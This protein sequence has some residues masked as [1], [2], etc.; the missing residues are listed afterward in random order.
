VVT[1]HGQK[2]WWQHGLLHRDGGRPAVTHPNGLKEWWVRGTLHRYGGLLTATST[3][4]RLDK[5]QP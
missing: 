1:Y 5:E 3:P 2:E 4:M